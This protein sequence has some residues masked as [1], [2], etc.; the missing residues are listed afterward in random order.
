MW[1]PSAA[2]SRTLGQ[3][4]S[5]HVMPRNSIWNLKSPTGKS[6]DSFWEDFSACQQSTGNFGEDFGTNFGANFGENFGN[7]VSNF[8]TFFRNFVQQKGGANMIQGG[9]KRMGGGKRTE[10]CTLPKI[11][12]RASGLLSRGFLYRKTEQRHPTGVE[13][14]PY[15]GGPKPLFGRGCH[16]WGL[17]PA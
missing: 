11:S 4:L 15:E 13:N 8:A 3:K 1:K 2:S 7:F 9:A 6:G 12:K 16:S 5:H 10:A 14:V 17:P